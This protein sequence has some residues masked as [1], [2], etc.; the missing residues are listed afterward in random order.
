MDNTENEKKYWRSIE[1]WK[2]LS[3]E[4]NATTKDQEKPGEF[5][6]S[7]LKE[8]TGRDGHSRREF[9]KLM[10]A[11][12]AMMSASA[13]T[14]RPIEKIIPF[15]RKP[16]EITAGVAN[17]YASTCRECS[18]SCGVLVKTR[19]GRPLKFEGQPTHPDSQGGL[20]ARGQASVLNVYDPDR[21]K[22]PALVKRQGQSQEQSWGQID[23]AM[24]QVLSQSKSG[25]N[26]VRIL[27][28]ELASP[29]AL[30]LIENF[31]KG[32]SNAQHITYEVLASEEIAQAAELTYGKRV[33]PH[34]RFDQA[35][36]IL[37][38]GADFLGNWLNPVEF[39]KAF[40]K[41][42]KLGKISGNGSKISSRFVA[43]ESLLTLT[44]SNADERYSIPSGEEYKVALAFAHYF[45]LE[46]KWSA[47]QSNPIFQDTLAGYS[48]KNV[49]EKLGL[50]QAQMTKIAEELWAKRG[51]SLV[52]GGGH[53][54]KGD[55]G[56]YLEL[57]VNLLNTVLENEGVTVDGSVSWL[58][59]FS[60]LQRL[61]DLIAEMKA[62]QVDVLIIHQLNPVFSFPKTLGFEDALKKVA[63]IYYLT[64]RMDETAKVVDYA[65]ALSHAT[66]AWG[67]ASSRVGVWSI[68]QPTISPMYSTRSLEECLLVWG[69]GLGEKSGFFSHS[70][71]HDALQWNWKQNLG[72]A[73]DWEDILR[74]GSVKTGPA[75]ANG[76]PARNFSATAMKVIPAT[77]SWNLN[78]FRLVIY[79]KIATYDGRHANNGW[80][81]ELPDPV[82][83]I[84]WD[85][86]FMISDQDSK[87]MNLRE[88]DKIRLSLLSSA[89]DE[90]E[91][92]VHIQPG[93]K[94]KTCG[95]ALGYGRTSAGR[96]GNGVGVQALH[97]ATLEQRTLSL[98]ALP[99]KFE[100]I[101]GHAELACTQRHN[102]ME[103]RPIIKETSLKKYQKN[104]KAGNEHHEHLTTIW[105]E[106]KYHGYRWGMAI[107]LNSCT[108]CSA[109]VI[110]CQ[111]EN[112]IPVVGKSFVITNR[113]M[114]WL[115]ID[116]YYSGR[117]DQPEVVHQPMLCQH[118]E[119]A[120]CET[121]CPVLA[122][123]H[124]HEGLNQQIYNRCVGTRYC[125]NNCPYKVRR[126][127]WFTFTDVV[128]PLNL[129]FNP[130]VTV[131]T[132]GVMEKCTFC[133]QRI[134]DA[135]DHAKDRGT[136]VQDGELKTACQQS[137]PT[138]AIVFGNLND[139]QSRVSQI[140][141]DPRGY[142]V[143][144]ELNVR[145]S[146][147]YLT[148]IR[149]TEHE[150]TTSSHS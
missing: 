16:E 96:V 35:D 30:A 150:S 106:H 114:H 3:E 88:G 20:C 26:R 144:E 89:R 7:P 51:K 104:P 125:A 44:G 36:Y 100:K 77:P 33:V 108:G 81:Q 47:Y 78:Q 111:S 60:S 8:D 19:D 90:I 85:N 99:I 69:K 91:L 118:C 123:L 21:L 110:G 22:A 71:W 37:S 2:S 92:P 112:N 84:T 28:G 80:L 101:P 53:Q 55:H 67:D 131:R 130:D 126:F 65:L 95:V 52:L 143:L 63:K 12:F 64:D 139:P 72:S 38:F 68:Q 134:Q 94:E 73:F 70:S 66:E 103:G 147:T 138:D 29:S 133:V 87:N 58:P 40:S 105:P 113:E 42:K 122:T 115:R 109:C 102:S 141:K 27:T 135:K 4:F 116:R 23:E 74:N 124:D 9:L 32:F 59:H 117:T 97:L 145:P 34:Y 127:N 93:L 45:I 14:R 57:A 31:L 120:P 48:I 132:R 13:C 24:T 54:T 107:D 15:A 98:S 49:S 25:G 121:V 128:E 41:K 79:P 6:S 46:K 146:I 10:G 82:T 136:P 5:L 17:W 11:S 39:S 142:H 119:N 129:A 86:Y 1:E 137:C 62:G 76:A 149:N 56:L 148:K 75:T 140:S 83:K 61:K 43:F 18:A 50:P